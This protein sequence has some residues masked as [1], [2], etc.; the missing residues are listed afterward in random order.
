MKKAFSMIELIIV[1]VVVAILAITFLPKFNDNSKLIEAGNQLTSHIRYTQ[2][3]AMSDNRFDP[4]TP[5]WH[6][7]EW[8]IYFHKR[9]GD[10]VYTIFSDRNLGGQPNNSE[11]AD[12]PIS[13]RK[14]TGDEQYS[15]NFIS[16]M[17][18]TKKFG[19]VSY[20]ICGLSNSNHKRVYFDHLGRPYIPTGLRDDNNPFREILHNDCVITF[21][22][23]DNRELNITIRPETGYLTFNVTKE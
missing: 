13:G 5:K 6:Q 20:S 21:K 10:I 11:I 14:M 22:D 7:K 23:S 3:L 9:N 15:N 4:S 2:H 19:I 16:S 8:Q 12:D 1:I 17:N 18:L